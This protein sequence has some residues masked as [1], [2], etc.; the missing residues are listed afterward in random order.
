VNTVATQ[1]N[2]VTTIAGTTFFTGTGSFSDQRTGWVVGGGI[3]G[4][5]GANWTAKLEYLY[6]DFGSIAHLYPAAIPTNLADTNVH[7][8]TNVRDTSAPAAIIS[9]RGIL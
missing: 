4:A 7:I 3:E 2:T 9:R 1:I 5:I 8:S 6:M